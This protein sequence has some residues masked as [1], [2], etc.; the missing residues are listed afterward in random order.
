LARIAD[1]I[2]RRDFDD[3]EIAL[4]TSDAFVRMLKPSKTRA[5]C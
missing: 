5:R 4:T 3:P 1:R 2:D